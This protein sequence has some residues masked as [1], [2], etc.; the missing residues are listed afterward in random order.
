MD[1]WK[2][3]PAVEKCISYPYSFSNFFWCV[4]WLAVIYSASFSS[5]PAYMAKQASFAETNSPIQLTP[6]YSYFLHFLHF[7]PG[8]ETKTKNIASENAIKTKYPSKPVIWKNRDF[9][10]D[11]FWCRLLFLFHPADPRGITKAAYILLKLLRTL[12]KMKLGKRDEHSSS[13]RQTKENNNQE[14]SDKNGCRRFVLMKNMFSSSCKHH[15][16]YIYKIIIIMQHDMT[17]VGWSLLGGHGIENWKPKS[18][19]IWF[20]CSQFFPLSALHSHINHGHVRTSTYVPATTN[21]YVFVWPW[22]EG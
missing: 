17:S 7:Q 1:G 8:E 22:R 19:S 14:K 21:E 15:D 16:T 11:F 10:E 4:P 2:K 5:G 18:G 9:W 6:L 3:K 12:R 13:S 20:S